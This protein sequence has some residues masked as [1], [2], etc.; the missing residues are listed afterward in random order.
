MGKKILT[1]IFWVTRD[2]PPGGGVYPR[3]PLGGSRPNPPPPGSRSFFKFTKKIH[4]ISHMPIPLLPGLSFEGL[5]FATGQRGPGPRRPPP[6]GVPRPR[7]PAPVDGGGKGEM[8]GD[9]QL[10]DRIPRLT[11]PLAESSRRVTGGGRP[12]VEVRRRLQEEETRAA[13][14]ERWGRRAA[15]GR[16]DGSG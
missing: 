12:A 2:L 1:L 15:G 10:E 9:A 14:E 5:L 3:P 7:A 13:A 16:E 8:T 11:S 6:P 4:R